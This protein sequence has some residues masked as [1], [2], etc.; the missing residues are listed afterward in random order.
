MTCLRRFLTLLGAVASLCGY[1]QAWSERSQI[2]FP[3]GP[4]HFIVLVDSSTGMVRSKS[5]VFLDAKTNAL[6]EAKTALTSMLFSPQEGSREPWYR[7]GKDRITVVHFGIGVGKQDTIAKD[8]LKKARLD[9]DYVRRITHAESKMSARRFGLVLNPRVRTHFDLLPWAL[10]LG[11]CAAAVPNYSIQ[12]TYLLVLTDSRLN[13]SRADGRANLAKGFLNPTARQRLAGQTKLF[14]DS[15]QEV[16]YGGESEVWSQRQFGSGDDQVVLSITKLVP[17]T[18]DAAAT[19]LAQSQPFTSLGL[20]QENN[21]LVASFHPPA[22]LL[23]TKATVQI[24][25][26]SGSDKKD[27]VLTPNALVHLRDP[28]GWTAHIGLIFHQSAKNPLLGRQNFQISV[29]ETVTLPSGLRLGKLLAGVIVCLVLCLLGVW[30]YFQAVLARHVQLW[31]PGYVTSFKLPPL[32]QRVNSNHI[33]RIPV[34]IG[35]LA[36]IV[37]LPPLLIRYLFYSNAKLHWDSRL[38]LTA[39]KADS[40]SAKLISMPRVCKFICRDRT[41]AAGEFEFVFER[42]FKNGRNQRAQI[43]VRFLALSTGAQTTSDQP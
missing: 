18:T 42:N 36:A 22:A 41:Y 9:Q 19:A 27:L 20:E 33:V 10:P 5:Q 16:A 28:G 12:E 32:S 35:D 43:N 24:S 3:E 39:L 15:V 4:R 6:R 30:V 26:R 7:K 11:V 23:G 13:D 2:T 37:V 8:A 29:G 31:M 14:E 25:S 21:G 17:A 34:E 38:A 40:V 1:S